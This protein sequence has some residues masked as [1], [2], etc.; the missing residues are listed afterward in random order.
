M[1]L[2]WATFFMEIGDVFVIHATI[3]VFRGRSAADVLG[4]Q[5]HS[6]VI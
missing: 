1:V 5:E 6:N 3:I 2:K 4:V